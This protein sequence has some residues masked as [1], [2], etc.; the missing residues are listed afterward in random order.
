MDLARSPRKS[1]KYIKKLEDKIC[2]LEYHL[3]ELPQYD[4]CA[5]VM[6]KLPRELR[7]L[8]YAGL[9]NPRSS[10]ERFDMSC[11]EPINDVKPR[12]TTDSQFLINR[13]GRKFATELFEYCYKTVPIAADLQNMSHMVQ[14]RVVPRWLPEHT[15]YDILKIQVHVYVGTRSREFL[16]TMD[17]PFPYATGVYSGKTVIFFLDYQVYSEESLCLLNPIHPDVMRGILRRGLQFFQALIRDGAEVR[18]R[19]H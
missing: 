13:F 12:H 5:L 7:D 16:N 3:V 4:V 14:H 19:M 11:L 18:I 15:W 17:L 1:R 9:V 10:T 6:K 2:K 8:V